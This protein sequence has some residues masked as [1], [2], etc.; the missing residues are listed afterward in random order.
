MWAGASF[1]SCPAPVREDMARV[2]AARLGLGGA[3][4]DPQPVEV[5]LEHLGLARAVAERLVVG[6]VEREAAQARR[7]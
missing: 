5:A 1:T 3:A 6:S 4:V 7:L 2:G